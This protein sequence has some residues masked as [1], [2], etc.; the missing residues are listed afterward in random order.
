MFECRSL[1]IADIEFIYKNYMVNDFPKDELKPLSMIK[2]SISK[3]QY[4][5]FGIYSN[6]ELCGYAFFVCLDKLCLL[7]YLAILSDRRGTGIGSEF[8]DLLKN[9]MSKFD[10]VI[11]EA[12]NPDYSNGKELEIRQKRVSFYFRNGFA[13]TTVTTNVFGAEFKLLELNMGKIHSR[14]EV[15]EA[16]SSLYKSFLPPAA[17]NKVFHIHEQ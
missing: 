5:C 15:I 16:Y 6:D 1:S 13:D 17:Y 8:I 4:E 2:K 10:I 9:E 3:S 7:D 12:D 14:D 11:C